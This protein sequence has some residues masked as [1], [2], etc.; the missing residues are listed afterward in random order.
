MKSFLFFRVIP[1]PKSPS[2]LGKTLYILYT[3]FVADVILRRARANSS[4]S[5]AANSLLYGEF[6]SHTLL[7][8]QKGGRK[9][10]FLFFFLYILS[11]KK[12]KKEIS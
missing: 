12:G 9:F 8:S 7:S 5:N 2:Q 3:L 11:Q 6:T 10:P 1:L 4:S